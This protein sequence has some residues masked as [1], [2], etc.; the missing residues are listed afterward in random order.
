MIV[1]TELLFLDGVAEPQIVFFG[2][3]V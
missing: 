3:V 2:A 1:V